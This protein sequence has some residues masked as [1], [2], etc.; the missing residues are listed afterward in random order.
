MIRGFVRSVITMGNQSEGGPDRSEGV[1]SGFRVR[2]MEPQRNIYDFEI[3]IDA[4]FADELRTL[5]ASEN[6]EGATEHIEGAL[7]H[8]MADVR[9]VGDSFLLRG[10]TVGFQATG[11]DLH[12]EEFGRKR[13]ATHNVDSSSE[14]IEIIAAFSR[15]EKLAAHLIEDR[16]EDDGLRADGGT[17]EDGTERPDYHD[18]SNSVRRNLAEADRLYHNAESWDDDLAT[19]QALLDTLSTL[20][21]VKGGVEQQISRVENELEE[22]T[23]NAA[24]DD[25][26]GDHDE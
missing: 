2:G 20:R 3:S 9:F 24:T 14:A 26:R 18:G 1:A 8:D 21:Q 16:R 15:W 4:E 7:T 22:R 23:Q 19:E 25:S 5:D 11:L 12:K 10:I 17:V 6:Q 13:Y